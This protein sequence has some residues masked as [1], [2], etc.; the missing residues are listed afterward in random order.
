M[1]NVVLLGVATIALPEVA[2]ELEAICDVPL[3]LPLAV[4]NPNSLL[5]ML[6]TASTS[7]V[8][9][10][11][12]WLLKLAGIAVSHAVDREFSQPSGLVASSV[13]FVACGKLV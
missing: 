11:S 6:A 12:Y 1:T 7:L 9:S 10:A 4:F 3:E 2:L 8:W 13:G 5:K